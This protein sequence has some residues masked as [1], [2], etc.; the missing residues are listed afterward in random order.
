[1]ASNGTEKIGVY[2]LYDSIMTI[3]NAKGEDFTVE[4]IEGQIR[5][6]RITVED[7]VYKDFLKDVLNRIKTHV[8]LKIMMSCLL[9]V[10]VCYLKIF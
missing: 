9:G 8:N 5:R 6:G 4:R 2:D 3:E 7:K 1:M 10:V